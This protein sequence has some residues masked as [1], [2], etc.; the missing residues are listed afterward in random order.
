[1]SQ[2]PTVNDMMA[3]YSLDAVDFARSQFDVELDFSE[4]SV[5]L[6]EEILEE[7]YATMPKGIIGK[8]LSKKPSPEQIDR[9]AKM[10]GGYV[11]EV[12]RRSW[13]GHW[14]LETEAFPRE[15]VIT[16]E[17]AKGGDVWPHFKA[18]KRLVNGPEDNVW[19][20]FLYLK[21]EADSPA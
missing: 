9:M 7:L 4:A 18:G 17:L 1:M 6:I 14:K 5:E 2:T 11:G 21:D 3:A 19:H 16:L 15:T 8:T 20:Y 12:M 10:L 13:G